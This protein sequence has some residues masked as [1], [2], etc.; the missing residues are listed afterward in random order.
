MNPTTNNDIFLKMNVDIGGFIGN[1]CRIV[2]WGVGINSNFF[3]VFM[4]S[5]LI[6]LL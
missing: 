4:I 6:Y 3:V 2:V 5:I 1:D